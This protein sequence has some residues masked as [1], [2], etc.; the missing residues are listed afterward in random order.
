MI[1]I[2]KYSN[3]N[4][5]RVTNTESYEDM[6][7]RIGGNSSGDS[8]TSQL[9]LQD[10][11]DILG[12]IQN[13]TAQEKLN[14]IAPN[15]VPTSGS[16]GSSVALA[17]TEAVNAAMNGGVSQN[18][19]SVS[20]TSSQS[21]SST[22]QRT[23][24]RGTATANKTGSANKTN[25]ASS[26][27]SNNGTATS[28][29]RGTVR[30]SEGYAKSVNPF[31]KY[32]TGSKTGQKS[33]GT[34]NKLKYGKGLTGFISNKLDAAI[35]NSSDGALAKIKT[36]IGSMSYSSPNFSGDKNNKSGI[37]SGSVYGA[38]SSPVSTTA[39]SNEQAKDFLK[40]SAAKVKDKAKEKS[41]SLVQK[42][43]EKVMTKVSDTITKVKTGIKN[44]VDG[45]IVSS[46]AMIMQKVADIAT[47]PEPVLLKTMQELEEK[48]GDFSY[49]G[50]YTLS[51]ILERDYASILKWMMGDGKRL[52][53]NDPIN[54][55]RGQ[56]AT[57]C[58]QICKKY[59]ATKC[60]LLILNKKREVRGEKWYKQRRYYELKRIICH[61]KK[62]FTSKAIID[63]MNK[64][65]SSNL[66]MIPSA[67][68][69]RGCTE[70]KKMWMFSLPEVN[71]FLPEKQSVFTKKWITY[72]RTRAHVDLMKNFLNSKDWSEEDKM[73]HKIIHKRLYDNIIIYN[74]VEGAIAE[75]LQDMAQ[76]TGVAGIVN[77]ITVKEAYLYN[78]LKYL[79]QKQ[80]I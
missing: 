71:I 59:G 73:I 27:N 25:S 55:V 75:G 30:D 38:N 34:I 39:V 58:N 21:A 50:Y 7:A 76:D 77:L 54:V 64:Y 47:I 29:R 70:T 72:P 12:S 5:T 8:L 36:G 46:K 33:I 68:G 23:S 17:N 60:A 43:K 10:R 11:I 6:L 42:A 79:K 52:T 28:T 40:E 22:S 66:N 2:S 61:G 78:Y 24:R 74:D 69:E 14:A 31:S 63:Q 80:L 15:V 20:R 16:N 49:A 32:V 56:S 41:N 37:S 35:P 13:P 62:N 45:A 51:T 1:D 48:G 4:I 19:Q 53:H 3:S 26:S 18:N 44:T 67:F 57:V 65:E 9:D